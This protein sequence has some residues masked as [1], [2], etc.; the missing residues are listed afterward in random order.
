MQLADWSVLTML[1]E[2]N[3]LYKTMFEMHEAKHFS[4]CISFEVICGNFK[5]VLLQNYTISY[6]KK[7]TLVYRTMTSLKVI[8]KMEGNWH[9][10]LCT[11]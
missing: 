7:L 1:D 11:I 5:T 6:S 10:F 8:S 2:G 3:V 4:D 9:A